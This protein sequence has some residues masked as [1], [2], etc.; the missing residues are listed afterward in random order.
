MFRNFSLKAI[1]PGLLFASSAIGTSH[2]VL[3]TRAGA[4]HGMIYFW[5]IMIALLLKYPFYEFGPR[6]ASSTGFSLLKSYRDQGKWAVYLFLVVI[7]INMF[8]VVAAVGAVCAGL[9]AT[10][11]GIKFIS[12]PLLSGLV[13][14]I[15]AVLLLSRG[16][17][18]LETFIK[19]LSVVLVLTVFI[20][21]CSVLIKGPVPVSADFNPDALLEGGG[22]ALLISLLG[23]MPAGME[24]S[25][26]NSIWTV[27]KMNVSNYKPK[28]GESLFDFRLGYLMT[29]LLAI[30]FMTIGAYTVYGSGI[31]LE[32]NATAFT[33]K[34]LNLFA[35]SLGEWSYYIIGIAAFGTIYGTLIAVLDAFPRCFVR[36]LRVLKY[37]NIEK[38]EEQKS[39]LRITYRY[40]VIAVSIGG[41]A[42]FYFSSASMIQMLEYVT[43]LSF[44][45]SP[46]IAVLNLKAIQSE[47]LDSSQK[48]GLVL[49]VLAYTGL[50][51]LVVFASY[52]IINLFWM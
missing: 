30:M 34:L 9:M 26:M 10:V 43:I 20:A 49:R 19:I 2:L 7:F 6:Y 3:S 21:F 4:H 32:G 44:L 27:E 51:A 35:S 12:V 25:T 33:G 23:W 38:S 17:S 29:A 45:L 52:Y 24:A 13:I 31:K 41:F 47:S 15:T 36:G 8:T 16:Y 14:G 50:V 48:P 1:G 11:F 18:G 39:F 5:I 40:T 46:V 42:L 28:L 22:L 37:E